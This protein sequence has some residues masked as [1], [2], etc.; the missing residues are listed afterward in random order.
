MRDQLTD[1]QAADAVRTRIDW[2]YAGTVWTSRIP[3]LTFLSGVE[4]RGRLL[5]NQA[6]RRLFDTMLSQLRERGWL[7]GLGASILALLS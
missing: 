1:R 7:M 2:K 3:G 6:E 4:F 5:T